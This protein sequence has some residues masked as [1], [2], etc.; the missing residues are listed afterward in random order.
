M[1]ALMRAGA[2]S[3]G[4]AFDGTRT[5]MGSKLTISCGRPFSVTSKSVAARPVTGMPRSS[6]TTSIRTSS[7]PA[8][9]VGGAWAEA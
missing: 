5:T 6:T 1:G 9:N 2:A 8:G 3:G 4:M 7:T